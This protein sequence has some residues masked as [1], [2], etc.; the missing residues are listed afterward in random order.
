MSLAIR[1]NFHIFD[2]NQNANYNKKINPKKYEMK[3][4]ILMQ[5][6]AI[7]KQIH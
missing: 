3:Y 7:Q 5:G 2:N 1:L 4:H 6:C